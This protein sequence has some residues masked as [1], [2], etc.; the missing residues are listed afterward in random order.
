MGFLM[1]R[2]SSGSRSFQKLAYF[3]RYLCCTTGGS[4]KLRKV[5]FTGSYSDQSTSYFC[6][7]PGPRLMNKSF[8][9]AFGFLLGE[10][11]EQE[12]KERVVKSA[13]KRKAPPTHPVLAK[14]DQYFMVASDSSRSLALNVLGNGPTSASGAPKT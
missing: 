10:E 9:G 3:S 5:R 6:Q 14:L 11:Q 13:I 2:N 1:C 12:E 4:P 8:H 7:S